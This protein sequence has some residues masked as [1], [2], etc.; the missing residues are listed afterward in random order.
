MTSGATAKSA[1]LSNHK[2]LSDAE[3]LLKALA[4]IGREP[5]HRAQVI[6][7]LKSLEGDFA[8]QGINAREAISGPIVDALHQDVDLIKKMLSTGLDISFRYRSKIARDFIMADDAEPDHC[9]EPQTTKL[10]VALSE[11]MSDVLIGGAYFG[12]QAMLVAQSI[13]DGGGRCHCFEVSTEQFAM[14]ETN[15]RNN[16]LDNLVANQ[17]GLWH[18]DDRSLILIGEDAYGATREVPKGGDPDAFPT[19]TIDSYGAANGIERLGLI[20]LDIE[21]AELAAL[22]GADG[23]LRRPAGEAPDIVFE[24]ASY[25]VGWED[26]LAKTEVVAHLEEL[27]YTVFAVRDYHRNVPMQG[28]P[29]E[30]IPVRDV[31]LADQPHGFNMLA[32][33]DE[34][35]IAAKDLRVCK[36]VSPKL[37]PHEDPKLHQPLNQ[38][39]NQAQPR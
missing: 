5:R 14:L 21:G 25:Y 13:K 26:G 39:P 3:D 36:G 8:R 33:K 7:L 4:Q 37:L 38:P 19:T 17:T 28:F 29:V 18:S 27:G 30:I 1:N 16:G 24:L 15:A 20:M 11:G 9:W 6:A 10:L 34:A 12:D 32:L 31:Y 35:V 22:Q 23:Y 2:T